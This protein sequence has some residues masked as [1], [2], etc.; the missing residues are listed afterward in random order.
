MMSS[1]APS[2]VN[3]ALL[4]VPPIV[5][6]VLIFH[7]SSESDPLP[8]LTEAVWDKALHAV[9][10]GGLA[11]LVCR[12]LRGEGCEWPTACVLAA[13]VAC[14]YA[15]SD[16]WHQ[17]MVPGRDSDIRDW[18]ADTIGGSLGVTLYWLAARRPRARP[19]ES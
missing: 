1:S 8:A 11:F 18:V 2:W 19:T 5:Y 6:A 13:V 10:Y 17:G 14:A 15:L 4:W 7:F 12:A 9:E 3:R 16:E